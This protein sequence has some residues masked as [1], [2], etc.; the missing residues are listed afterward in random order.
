[1]QESRVSAVKRRWSVLCMLLSAKHGHIVTLLA[2]ADQDKEADIDSEIEP[3]HDFSEDDEVAFDKEDQV[4]SPWNMQ[5][6]LT[7]IS[8]VRGTCL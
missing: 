7:F 6:L 5:G 1:M 4:R 2:S 3:K 8:T